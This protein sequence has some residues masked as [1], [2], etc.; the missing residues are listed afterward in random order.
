MKSLVLQLKSWMMGKFLYT[1]WL[2]L[3]FSLISYGQCPDLP[4]NTTLNGSTT[5]S[6]GVCGTESFTFNVNDPDL[7]SGT[8]D[9]YSSTT[10][11]FDPFTGGTLIGNSTIVSAAE[12][13]QCPSLEAIYIDACGPGADEK[14]NEFMVINS[15]S[16]FAV[17]NLTVD[18][19][20]LISQGPTDSDIGPGGCAW[21]IGNSSIYTGCSDLIDAG[22]GDYIPPNARVIIQ[23][24]RTANQTYDLSGLCGTGGCIYV[25]RNNCDR[26]NAAFSNFNGSTNTS[27]LRTQ[28][29]G[30]IGCCSESLTYDLDDPVL[31]GLGAGGDGS[32]TY[33][34]PGPNYFNDGCD[35]GPSLGALTMYNFSAVTDPFTHSFLPAECNTV[36]FVVGVLNSPAYNTDCCNNTEGQTNEY[37][38]DVS[39]ASAEIS[40]DGDGVLCPGECETITVT[41]TGGTAPY[42][43]NLNLATSAPFPLNNIPLPI[44]GFPLNQKITI[45]YDG[46]GP[47]YDPTTFTVNVPSIA[48]G[49]GTLSLNAFSDA[50]G[51]AG[52]IT[53]SSISLSFND[54]PVI[55]TPPPF[56]EC[57]MTGGSA[58]F[59]LTDYNNIINNNTGLPVNY[60]LDALGM[61]PLASPYETTST[62]I[63]AQVDGTPC[64]S[65]IV[66]IELEVILNGDVGL[67]TFF[68]T[69]A[70]GNDADCT[71]CDDDGTAGEDITLTIIFEDP[72]L[73]YNY[74]VV[75]TAAS[76]PSSTIV[77]NS[78]PGSGTAAVMFSIFET[79]T[80]EIT[81]VQ[82]AGGCPDMTD[83][84][85]I[86]TVNYSLE[87][88][89]ADP[90]ALSGCGSVTL[91]PINGTVVPANA[92]YFSQQN[93]AGTPS[94]PGDMITTSGTIYLFAG[95]DECQQEIPI[96]ITING[97]A[98]IDDP[99]PITTCGSYTL[100][101]I[102][103]TNVE[104]ANYYTGAGGSGGQLPVGQQITSDLT[105]FIFDPVCGG[106]EVEFDITITAGAVITT[107]P[108]TIVCDT[109]ILSIIEGLDLS[110]GE[111]YYS[112]A[113]GLGMQIPIGDTITM[114]TLIYIYDNSPGCEISVAYQITIGNQQYPGEDASAPIC[115]GDDT[116]YDLADLLG[117][118]PP[119]TTGRWIEQS[120]N[121]VSDSSMVDFSSLAAGQYV[122]LYEIRDSICGDTS[123]R[124][125]VTILDT[126]DAGADFVLTL[127]QDVTG[128]N[129]IDSLPGADLGGIFY[130]DAG[131]PVSFDPTDASFF[132][133]PAD[134]ILFHYVVG[135]TS[136]SCGVDKSVF[137]VVSGASTE[138]GMNR[139]ETICFGLS[140]D[141][142]DYLAGQSEI[143]TFSE[144][145]PSGGL[146]GSTFN[147]TLVNDGQAYTIYHIVQGSGPCPDDTARITITVV[148]GPSAGD[149]AEMVLC[150]D[151]TFDLSTLV[152]GDPGGTYYAGAT[153]L[154]SS[155]INFTTEIGVLDYSYII[156]DGV[157]CPFDTAELTIIRTIQPPVGVVA[158]TDFIC[159][160]ECVDVT[161]GAASNG[162][163][164]I[165]IYYRIT[166]SDGATD[167]RTTQIGDFTPNLMITFCEGDGLITDDI[168]T[169]GVSYEVVIDSIRVVDNNT[170]CSYLIGELISFSVGESLDTLLTG[171]YCQGT[172]ILVGTDVYDFDNQEGTTILVGQNGCDS[173]VVVDLEY[174]AA[175]PGTYVDILC[176]GGMVT[177]LGVEYT[178][179]FLGD[180]L[181][182]GASAGGC[183][184]LLTIDITIGSTA[185][186]SLDT[187]VCDGF[188]IEVNGTI[189]DASRTLGT[190]TLT[191][192]AASGCDSIVMIDLEFLI[193]AMGIV[194][195]VVCGS[196]SIIVDGTIYDANNTSGMEILEGQ[197]ANGC[198]SLVMIDL[199]FS[200]TS[201]DSMIVF[202]TCDND[203]FFVIGGTVY[204]RVNF[205]GTET[206]PS[207]TGGCDTL[208]T[209]DITYGEMMVDYEIQDATCMVPDT[210]MLV[211]N[212][213]N[214]QGPFD[215]MY[216]GNNAL[217][218]KAI[219]PYAVFLP[220]GSGT[221]DIVDKD[222][223]AGDCMAT[224]NYDIQPGVELSF[225]ITRFGDQLSLLGGTPDSIRWSP[226]ESLSCED[227]P[228]P[229]ASPESTTIY[230]ATV[231]Y[232]GDCIE[233][234]DFVFEVIDD[235]PDYILPN[236]FSP[237][238][239][240]SNENFTLQITDGAIGVP[241]SMTIYDRW[242]NK[243][244]ES[245][246][247]ASITST[248]WNG[249]YSGSIVS[250][251]VYVYQV[252]V[253]EG[254]QIINLFGDLTVI[255]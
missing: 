31:D 200:L 100:P 106:N 40:Q 217:V 196:F 95:I 150:G 9:W 178:S 134:T 11:G 15:G 118:A 164:T 68:C 169:A 185:M 186:G 193:E 136:L 175:V 205:Q 43:L 90:G 65:E 162:A 79:T 216:N 208:F 121:I 120:T 161:I 80:F 71:V 91:P 191:G 126:P 213:I 252:S 139:S 229:I 32:G 235:I 103:G 168:V 187:A 145:T 94:A 27:N 26:G 116:P 42:D 167:A 243:I 149:E 158:D 53:G 127:C 117:G 242:G 35:N 226:S 207:T 147:S 107:G 142:I 160:D 69:D 30:V 48:E 17:N 170:N 8:I 211:I 102:T 159:S 57:N 171:P 199:D 221:I 238:G 64:D 155:V 104:N 47:P 92:A 55:I 67:V 73:V 224:I 195:T 214:G 5:T 98:Q 52:T 88:Q 23:T 174:V 74:E 19:D 188:S 56:Q 254:T 206:V 93:G 110:G 232:G 135:D 137:S 49:A 46:T 111:A 4:P 153:A 130:D 76:G 25:I 230:M 239:D 33:A 2:L 1:F 231:Y 101:P 210:G 51:C 84:G 87:P 99:G 228:D 219:L 190:E 24:S 249:E 124:L 172:S 3:S 7:P 60:F 177:V 251:G 212:D 85:D 203:L 227:C 240:G 114:D 29:I 59:I 247:P 54:A 72:S 182:V 78:S 108:D 66:P 96:Q 63:Y 237:N 163:Q 77:G 250:S 122:Y 109:F 13:D 152:N 166:G 131:I 34:T 183:D 154:A 16:G 246:D 83:L 151:S 241:V 215:L 75:W 141:V 50:N 41:F 148:D 146:S 12:C 81:V 255:R 204:N 202:S 18:F 39:C 62:T 113:G 21:F 140:V 38:I 129:M 165:D 44:P 89:L 14:R 218:S 225:A 236:I 233:M 223:T 115:Q 61:I 82:T 201:I 22:P 86:V 28:G 253:I 97:A 119:D 144:P 36:Q 198:D 192:Q 112:E 194:D 138:A 234:L 105:V 156:G 123:S 143:G 209:I 37:S 180:T 197:A 70:M 133:N 189:Y 20:D 184:S 222:P 58:F 125:T 10:S 181:L 244:F 173:T 128:I 45:C 132:A 157:G 245:R 248:G 179:T 220:V 176:G 6:I